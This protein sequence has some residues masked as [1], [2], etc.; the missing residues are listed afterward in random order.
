MLS[1][2]HYPQCNGL[3]EA[4]VKAMKKLMTT[5]VRGELDEEN[6]QRGLL[7]YR[8]TPREGGLSPAQIL[9]G[10]PLR[11]AVPADRAAFSDK[12]QKTAN[13]YDAR[14]SRV[15]AQ[16][17][18]RYN[19]QSRSLQPL[20]IGAEVRVQHPTTKKRDRVGV[21][22]GIGQ[23]RDYHVKLPSG[24]VYWRNRRFLRSSYG[25]PP[26]EDATIKEPDDIDQDGAPCKNVH[27]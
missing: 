20:H 1:T 14:R 10:H 25:A 6:F 2:P 13:E 7:E 5:T 16:Y 22:I 27:T 11:S 4:A 17:E 8:N 18:E 24:R 9:F 19:A 15:L 23:H 26:N 3:A 21:T 12:W